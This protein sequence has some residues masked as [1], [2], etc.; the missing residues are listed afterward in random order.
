MARNLATNLARGRPLPSRSRR[1]RHL[2][3]GGLVAAELDPTKLS[4]DE[5]KL[6][7]DEL[8]DQMELASRNLEFELAARIRDQ[9][10]E[11]KQIQK[12][13]KKK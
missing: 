12:M 2:H 3:A 5:I 1:M 13:R 7:I 8:N 11:I 6:Y 9:I 4:M 10:T